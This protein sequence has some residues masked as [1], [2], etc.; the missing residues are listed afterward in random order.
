ML[1]P[2]IS[3]L[4]YAVSFLPYSW[5]FIIKSIFS[6]F[7]QCPLCLKRRKQP[8]TSLVMRVC[9]LVAAE[10]P[11]RTAYTVFWDSL[12]VYSTGV[13]WHFPVLL[14]IWHINWHFVFAVPCKYGRYVPRHLLRTYTWREKCDGRW[15]MVYIHHTFSVNLKAFWDNQIKVSE[16][17][18][19]CRLCRH[20][21]IYEISALASC[22]GG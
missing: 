17:N 8:I 11:L 12:L 4:Y 13:C 15:T 21:L 14:K 18:T 2:K 22:S 19:I 10:Q 6:I 7:S 16:C 20:F 3:L 5:C 9:R 1:R